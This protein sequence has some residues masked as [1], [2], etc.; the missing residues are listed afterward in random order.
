MNHFLKQCDNKNVNIIDHENEE[1]DDEFQKLR[2]VTT[3]M[4]F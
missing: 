4:Q 1:S 2:Q 3:A